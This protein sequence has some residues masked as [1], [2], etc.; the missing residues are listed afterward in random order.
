MRLRSLVATP[1][2]KDQSDQMTKLVIVDSFLLSCKEHRLDLSQ[3]R[4]VVETIYDYEI[5][6]RNDKDVVPSGALRGVHAGQCGSFSEV[7]ATVFHPPEVFVA[8]EV[9]FSQLD[10]LLRVRTFFNPV[11][12]DDLTVS[13]PPAAE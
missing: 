8:A 9:R 3:P 13:P 12:R 6:A 2:V 5:Q 11:F 1:R 4:F 7:Y 10:H